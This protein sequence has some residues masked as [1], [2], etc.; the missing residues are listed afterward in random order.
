M[1]GYWPVYSLVNASFSGKCCFQERVCF[2]VSKFHLSPWHSEGTDFQ[3]RG[4]LSYDPRA[5]ASPRIDGDVK[6]LTDFAY[7]LCAEYLADSKVANTILHTKGDP[8]K[9]SHLEMVS[10][11]CLGGSVG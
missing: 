6:K 4:V 10:E 1:G 9:V 8:L 11:G 3:S 5:P 7:L 2:L